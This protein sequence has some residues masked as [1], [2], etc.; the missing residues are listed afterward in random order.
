VPVSR[1]AADFLDAIENG[2]STVPGC[3]E[4]PRV[5]ALFDLARR[6]N[7]GGCGLETGPEIMEKRA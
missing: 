3:A 6:A 2:H 4:G 5:Q 1:L 7:N